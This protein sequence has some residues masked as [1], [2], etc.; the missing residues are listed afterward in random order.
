MAS[1]LGDLVLAMRCEVFYLPQRV[2]PGASSVHLL[3]VMSFCYLLHIKHF[4]YQAR[5]A[6]KQFALRSTYPLSELTP[7]LKDFINVDP[8]P[9]ILTSLSSN[10]HLTVNIPRPERC[11]LFFSSLA[12]AC[13]HILPRLGVEWDK[14]LVQEVSKDYGV[15]RLRGKYRYARPSTMPCRIASS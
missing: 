13:Y 3:L 15:Y 2:D 1:F 9:C 10:R 6:I 12:S 11:L 5:R 8:I 4:P 7:S 14:R